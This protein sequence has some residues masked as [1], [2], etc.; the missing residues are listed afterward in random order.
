MRDFVHV[1]DVAALIKLVLGRDD[2]SGE[3]YNAGSGKPTSIMDVA[4]I[5]LKTC[6]K[7]KDGIAYRNRDDTKIAHSYA[8]IEKSERIGYRPQ[9]KLESSVKEII[10]SY[11][12]GGC[13]KR[14]LQSKGG[15][16]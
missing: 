12:R 9:I 3:V 1:K 16:K 13:M 11:S 5:V 6:G 8:S 7:G 14:P 15:C 2:V 10:D 4:R